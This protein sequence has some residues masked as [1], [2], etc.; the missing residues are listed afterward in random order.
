MFGSSISPRSD[1]ANILGNLSKFDSNI[2]L[3]DDIKMKH[4]RL[5][6]KREEAERHQSLNTPISVDNTNSRSIVF[7]IGDYVLRKTKQNNKLHGS[8]NGPFL[9]IDQP[10][11][12]TLLLKNLIT[13]SELKAA[14]KDCKIYNADNPQD[15]EFLKAVAAGDAEKHVIEK[16]LSEYNSDSGSFCT[17]QWFGGETTEEPLHSVKHSE[18]YKLFSRNNKKIGK[19][20]TSQRKSTS[21][22]STPCKRPR[23]STRIRK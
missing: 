18:A 12:S 15:I 13:G 9:V 11:T 5:Q 1:P 14:K 19:R 16:I 21:N 22:N 4:T 3:L 2:P 6:E 10:S 17:V 20:T 23:R 8:W 7:N